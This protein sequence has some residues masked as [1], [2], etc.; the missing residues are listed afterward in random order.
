MDHGSVYRRCGCRDESTGRLL[1][2]RCPGLRSLR[3]G[4][5]YSSADLPSGTGQRRRVRRGGFATRAADPAALSPGDVQ[6]MFTAIT[7]DETVPGHPASAATLHRIHATLRAAAERRGPRRADPRQPGPVARAAEGYPAPA[8]GLDPGPG[9]A[10]AADLRQADRRPGRLRR[11][12]HLPRRAVPTPVL[13]PRRRRAQESRLRRRPVHPDHR[14][15][16][17]QRPRRPLP[18]SWIGLARPA[19]RPQPQGPQRPPPARG[20]RLPRHHHPS[21]GRRLNQQPATTA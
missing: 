6:A 18:G 4:R 16:P 7:R 12:Q 2:A 20:P 5:W 13:P 11:R 8:T 1:G 15:A 17:A 9:R 10:A 19:H 21:G 14:L 3:H